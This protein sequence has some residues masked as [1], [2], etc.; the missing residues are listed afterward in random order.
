[1]RLPEPALQ[2]DLRFERRGAGA[3][4]LARQFGGY[5]F[6]VGRVLSC[7]DAPAGAASVLLQ[8]CSGGL[9]EHDRVAVQVKVCSGAAA[10]VG[11]AAATVVHSMTSGIAISQVRLE[12]ESDTW[13]E[14]LPLLSI[15]FPQARLVSELDVVLHPGALIIL[16]DAFLAHDPQGEAQP[17]DVLDTCVTVRDETQRL[18][19]RDRVYV[20]GALWES[21]SAG[22]AATHAAQGSLLIL[23]RSHDAS[24]LAGI[25]RAALADLPNVYAG[26]GTLP[27]QSGVLVRILASGG[28]S[29]RTATSRAAKAMRA[30][31]APTPVAAARAVTRQQQDLEVDAVGP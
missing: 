23:T 8:S 22:V 31:L 4:F 18:L 13:L 20:T 28:V 17:F 25:L 7:A 6:H 3:T 27:N 16:T 30:A 19:V 24:E 1:M 10:R 14:Y 5:P 15:L 21:A 26:V 12:A 11:S 9:F 29:L 2:V